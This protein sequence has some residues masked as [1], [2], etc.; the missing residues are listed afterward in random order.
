MCIHFDFAKICGQKEL[1]SLGGRSSETSTNSSV[2]TPLP[3]Q[4]KAYL[5]HRYIKE[6]E[7]LQKARC[8]GD[9][10]RPGES[11]RR[12]ASPRELGVR[13]TA[14]L[15]HRPLVLGGD[16][17]AEVISQLFAD[18]GCTERERAR[19]AFIQKVSP[20]ATGPPQ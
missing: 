20:D 13:W 3:K 17:T 1:A 9:T 19:G 2:P 16:K 18:A 10:L 4:Q 5:V 6:L 12:E 14:G 11:L 8:G 7:A 15:T